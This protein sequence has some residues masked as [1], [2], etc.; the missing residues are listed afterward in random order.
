MGMEEIWRDIEG[1]E[2]LYKASSLGKIK[3]LKNEIILKP[4]ILKNRYCNISLHNHKQTVYPYHIIIAKAFPEICG[5]WFKGCQVHHIDFNPQNNDPNNL[6]VLT[7]KEHLKIHA[8]SEISKE[9]HRVYRSG[10]RHSEEAKE[11]MRISRL[12]FLF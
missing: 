5:K 10:K 6:I 1:Y 2:G 12:F 9:K 7:K 4:I 11:K 8:D 3:S